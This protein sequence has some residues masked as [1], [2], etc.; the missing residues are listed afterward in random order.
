ML[1]QEKYWTRKGPPIPEEKDLP[2]GTFRGVGRGWESLSP[3]MRREIWRDATRREAVERGLP[4]DVI[5]RVH[6]LTITG[7]LSTLDEYLEVIAITD[8]K[9][10]ALREDVERMERA[11]QQHEQSTVQIA[12]RETL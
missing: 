1:E 9:R 2:A 4:Q 8:S 6:A 3:G 11:D 10:P 7:S 12:A 5:A